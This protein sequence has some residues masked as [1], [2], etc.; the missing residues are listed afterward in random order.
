MATWRDSNKSQLVFDFWLPHSSPPA[1][2]L[3]L[4]LFFFAFLDF[5]YPFFAQLVERQRGRVVDGQRHAVWL[6]LC[7]LFASLFFFLAFARLI[8]YEQ[9]ARR[10]QWDLAA[11]AA[12]EEVCE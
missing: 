9:N 10:A 7:V 4:L 1:P 2:L 12:A 6:E 11:A 8:N 5:P 3:L